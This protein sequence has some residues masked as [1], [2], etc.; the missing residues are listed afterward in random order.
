ML[1]IDLDRLV[2]GVLGGDTGAPPAETNSDAATIDTIG[3]GGHDAAPD[4]APPPS[5]FVPPAAVPLPRSPEQVRVEQVILEQFERARQEAALAAQAEQEAVRRVQRLEAEVDDRQS[6]ITALGER[7]RQ[8]AARLDE[9]RARKLGWAVEAY[10]GGELQRIGFVADAEGVNELVR[11]LSFVQGVTASAD[12]AMREH[13]QARQ[14]L[15]TEI[16]QL[17][18]ELG[19]SRKRLG[20]ARQRAM[21]INAAAADRRMEAAVLET[22]RIVAVGGLVLPVAGANHFSDTFG[23]PRMTGTRL[24][25][26][27]QGTDIFAAPGTPVVAFERGV[28]ARVGTDLLGGVKLWLVGQSGTRYY[29]AHLLGYSPGVMDGLVVEAGRTLGFVGNTGNAIRT[30]PHLHFEVHPSGGR[31]VNPYPLLRW[32]A[33]VAESS[34]GAAVIRAQP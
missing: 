7:E 32:I 27:H 10:M 26:A 2:G 15:R 3:A 12:R 8:G 28:L 5:V 18:V 24:A 29:Y 33:A 34:G 16:Q 19:A 23:A 11:R 9:A 22:G 1:G 13:R 20:V 6:R 31:A 4:E 21:E 17:V 25:H 14:A 30:P